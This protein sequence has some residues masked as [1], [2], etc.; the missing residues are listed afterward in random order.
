MDFDNV[1]VK[2]YL[3]CNNIKRVQIYTECVVAPRCG[4]PTRHEHLSS[5]IG[6]EPI[7]CEHL[8]SCIGE[9]SDRSN[10]INIFL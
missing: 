7:R 2:I 8:S 5:C 4:Q 10:D 3:N 6:T 1:H 9:G